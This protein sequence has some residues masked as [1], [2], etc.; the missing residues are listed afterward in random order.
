[1]DTNEKTINCA[2]ITNFDTL[3]DKDLPEFKNF[4]LLSC[5]CDHCKAMTF[6]NEL[7]IK[8]NYGG[9][10]CSVGQVKLQ[11]LPYCPP[12][13][14]RLYQGQTKNSKV[15]IEIYGSILKKQVL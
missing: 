13:L 2:R 5:S 1:L 4:G 11:K 14:R 7:N 15:T 10:C 9:L 6:E 3:K 8:K 12:T